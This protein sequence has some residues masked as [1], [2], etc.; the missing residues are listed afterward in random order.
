MIAMVEDQGTLFNPR[1]Y[2]GQKPLVYSVVPATAEQTVLQTIP[3]YRLYLSNIGVSEY[4][5][6][7]Y[8]G[9]IKLLGNYTQNRPLSALQ[10]NDLRQ[11]I[12][13]LKGKMADTTISRKKS[14]LANYFN[15]LVSERVLATNP[16]QGMRG[17]RVTS[18]APDLLYDSECDELLAANSND[19]R[20][21][22]LILLLLETGMKKAELMA[23]DVTH[24]DFSDKY[25]PVVWIK[26]SGKKTSKDRKLKLPV[27]KVP[28][29]PVFE[30]YVERYKVTGLLF[31]YTERF[32]NNLL[33][34]ASM[35]AKLR[36]RATA[37]ML[38]DICVV[39]GVRRGE[40]L[41]TM[42]ERIGLEKNSY[43]DARKKYGRLLS[44][45]L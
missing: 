29:V 25:Q 27:H 12:E 16:A 23:L 22:L 6:D 30:D 37:S 1:T 36:M 21:Y 4:T 38:R 26:H 3:A 42:L 13:S 17:T 24:F 20:T 44:E 7:D 19:P 9:D 35:R 15:W 39:R 28:I 40:K 8:A 14:A 18:P 34:D 41:E 11:W 33:A 10:A 5:P 32:I 45:A 2:K 31:P 43:D